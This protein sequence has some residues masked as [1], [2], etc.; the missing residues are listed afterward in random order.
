MATSG[1]YYL[2]APNL[3]SATAVFTDSA[4]SVCAPDGFYSD[5]LIVREQVGCVL[6]PQ[7][8]CPSCANSCD[9]T[10]SGSG[11]EGIY[12]INVD[13]GDILGAIIIRFTRSLIK[14]PHEGYL[15]PPSGGLFVVTKVNYDE[16][17]AVLVAIHV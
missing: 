12:Y 15:G 1:T 7:V 8:S 10:V 6:L 9:S 4:L 13:T 11:G 2:N 17:A 14:Q 3:G 16:L 5:G